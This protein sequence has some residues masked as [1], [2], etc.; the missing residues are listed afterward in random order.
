MDSLYNDYNKDLIKVYNLWEIEEK[1]YKE[2]KDLE[3]VLYTFSITLLYI[4]Y[5]NL[6]NNLLVFLLNKNNT[7][8][9]N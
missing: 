6:Q 7:V 5:Y 3:L 2:Y 8:S 4:Y 1:K 9:I